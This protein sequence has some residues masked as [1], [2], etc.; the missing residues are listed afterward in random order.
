MV[1]RY[2][3]LKRNDW[4]KVGFEAWKW[5]TLCAQCDLERALRS[6]TRNAAITIGGDEES[7]R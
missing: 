7:V 5:L 6:K 1:D 3:R 2:L 4:W